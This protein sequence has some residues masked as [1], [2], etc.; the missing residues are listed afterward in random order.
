MNCHIATACRWQ[1]ASKRCSSIGAAPK[2]PAAASPAAPPVDQQVR[3]VEGRQQPQEQQPGIAISP[4][5]L[6]GVVAL[7]LLTGGILAAL[8]KSSGFKTFFRLFGRH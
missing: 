3:V 5:A 8:V 1:A 4:I 2:A 6:A 7:A